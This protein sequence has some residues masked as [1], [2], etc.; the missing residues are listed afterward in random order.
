VGRFHQISFESIDEAAAFVAALSRQ[1]AGQLA[2]LRADHAEIAAAIRGSRADVF[3]SGDALAAC[4]RAFGAP[5]ETHPAKRLPTDS[6]VLVVS[7]AP[8]AL[9]RD[10][11]LARL[12]AGASRRGPITFR[13]I[14]EKDLKALA[15][16]RRRPHVR[17]WFGPPDS[18][19][20]M[21]AEF[22]EG[23]R[24]VRGYIGEIE[25]RP[26]GFIQSYVA[27]DAGDGWWPDERD[28]G[29]RGIDQFLAEQSEL[30]QGLGTRMVR[31]FVAQLFSD[32]AVTKVQTDPS[33]TN[34]RAIRCY[35]KAGFER[36]GVVHTPDGIALLMLCTREGFMA[37]APAAAPP[38]S[39]S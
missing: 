13:P 24:Q 1:V 8:E 12:A 23:S 27:K 3:L 22:L 37:G 39:R 15:E 29:A 18:I 32:P 36:V 16:W 2:D 17:K 6:V 5:P 20:E 28:P 4:E 14:G 19:Q 34:A 26:I 31:E 35:E 33:P 25:G 9:G 21:R 10:D 38:P 7:G 11:V 30:G